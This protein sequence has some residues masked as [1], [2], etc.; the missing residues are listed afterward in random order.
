M[1]HQVMLYIMSFLSATDLVSE[2]SSISNLNLRPKRMENL[3]KLVLEKIPK[4][5]TPRPNTLKPNME[6]S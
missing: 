6:T 3:F 5:S 2:S 1:A 4:T